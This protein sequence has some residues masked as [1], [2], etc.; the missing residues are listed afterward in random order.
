M[1]IKKKTSSSG[2]FLDWL[3][4]RHD[5]N[6]MWPVHHP[7][8]YALGNYTP[9]RHHYEDMPPY[10]YSGLEDQMDDSYYTGSFW[11]L[12]LSSS[13]NRDAIGGASASS[14]AQDA[15]TTT[16]SIKTSGE[17]VSGDITH[18]TKISLAR[19]KAEK[20][21]KQVASGNFG[22]TSYSGNALPTS[23]KSKTLP[24][25]SYLRYNKHQRSLSESKT[26]DAISLLSSGATAFP[27]ISSSG[28][29][30]SYRTRYNSCTDSNTS[31]VSSCESVTGRAAAM[32]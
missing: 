2:P 15:T 22:G 29:N 25:G 27:Q 11:N 12:L 9:V 4:V 3:S 1:K 23:A 17:E 28:F 19:P 32:G 20:M 6:T 30:Q 8:D 26:A 31:G 18:P 13:T 10:N 5:K 24:E 21:C 16:D 7:E 14:E